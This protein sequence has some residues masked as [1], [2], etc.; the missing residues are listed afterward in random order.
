M[1]TPPQTLDRERSTIGIVGWGRMGA[2]MGR[3]LTA[4]GWRVVATDPSPAA[5]DDV[6]ASGAEL[7]ET[8]DAVARV[9][10]LVLLVVVD[11]DQ[12]REVI[13]GEAGALTTARPGAVL[14]ICA[15]VRPDTCR[16][17]AEAARPNGVHVVDV[18]LVGGERGAEASALKLFCGGDAEVLDACL[19]AFAPFATDVCAIGAVGSGQVAKTANNLLLWACIRADY[20]A[21]TLA[22]ELG[23]EPGKL[24]AFLNVGTGANRPLADWGAHRLRWPRKDLDVAL[25]LAEEHGVELPLI[26]ELAP[27]MAELS[28]EDL[29]DLR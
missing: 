14:A 26:T 8:V 2:S 27:L 9:S 29:A 7:L 24:R 17:L 1:A 23:V 10:D 18:A 6:N 21:M 16:E 28:V 15:S 19:P 11:D 3:S 12:V 20:E 25:A 22:R 5:R 13:V 4:A